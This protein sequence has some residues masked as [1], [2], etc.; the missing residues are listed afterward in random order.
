LVIAVDTRCVRSEG[1]ASRLSS[2]PIVDRSLTVTHLPGLIPYLPMWE[3][4][5]ALALARVRREIG[6]RLLLLEHP[7]LYTIGRGGDRRHLLADPETLER[8]GATY[9]EV[10]RGG[11]I[12]YHGPGQLVGYP[13]ISLEGVGLTVRS[14][15]RG[16]EAAIIRAVALAGVTATTI[17]GYTGV[18]VGD[19]K[20]AAIGVRVSR[21]VAYHGF[22]LNVAPDLSYFRYIVPCGISDRGVTSLTQLTGCDVSVSQLASLCTAALAEV[23]GLKVEHMTGEWPLSSADQ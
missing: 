19:Q 20:L 15:V 11:D 14:Y 18:W 2:A 13:I 22:A 6:D 23:F 12:T 16:L 17:P 9:H 7:H 3:H 4:Q 10:D 8:I 5:R 21:G 1:E